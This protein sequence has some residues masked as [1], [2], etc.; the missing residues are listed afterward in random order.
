MVVCARAIAHIA[1]NNGDVVHAQHPLIRA[2]EVA[3]GNITQTTE[4][5]KISAVF[6]P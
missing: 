2:V 5:T 3:D 1:L 6:V 4:S